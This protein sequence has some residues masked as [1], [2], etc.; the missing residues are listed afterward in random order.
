MPKTVSDL[1]QLRSKLLWRMRQQAYWVQDG[2][3]D[4]AIAKLANVYTAI[5]AI[6]ELVELGVDEPD[7]KDAS[8]SIM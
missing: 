6:D 2:Y 8:D 3:H 4:E 1:I 5:Q 7:Q